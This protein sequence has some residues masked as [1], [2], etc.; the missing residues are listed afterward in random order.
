MQRL[1]AASD[2]GT[3]GQTHKEV[4]RRLIDA[5]TSGK[6]SPLDVVSAAPTDAAAQRR[7]PAPILVLAKE[8]LALEP[9][10]RPTFAEIAARLGGAVGAAHTRP[11]VP[12]VRA[13]I[14][15]SRST[16]P[17]L[18]NV[19]AT[20]RDDEAQED[21]SGSRSPILDTFKEVFMSFTT[22][23]APPVS[24]PYPVN[25]ASEAAAAGPRG[26]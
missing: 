5:V 10:A 20:F 13:D 1:H 15:R 23:A 4:I 3:A 16:V 22:G 24:D 25:V 21:R 14:V 6:A 12:L 7:C 9:S 26:A 2:G 18:D 17:R 19:S 11:T 8:C